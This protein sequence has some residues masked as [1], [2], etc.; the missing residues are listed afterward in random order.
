MTTK[1]KSHPAV[2]IEGEL[3]VITE[4]ILTLTPKDLANII[5]EMEDQGIH[6]KA[7][8]EQTGMSWSE[9]T[10]LATADG[11]GDQQTASD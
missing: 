9:L 6:V 7:S 11:H 4:D 8:V 10:K 3:I 5:L 1:T 2:R